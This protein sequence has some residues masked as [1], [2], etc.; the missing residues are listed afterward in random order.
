MGDAEVRRGDDS[1]ALIDA[2][3]KVQLQ[4]AE[5]DGDAAAARG[6]LYPFKILETDGGVAVWRGEVFGYGP[7][8]GGPNAIR[9]VVT[10]V[11]AEMPRR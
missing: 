7:N 9:S 11:R 4:R 1:L 2:V 3:A 10:E 8:Y 5:A 6:T